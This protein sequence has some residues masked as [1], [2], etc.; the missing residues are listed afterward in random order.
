MPKPHEA[1]PGPEDAGGVSVTLLGVSKAYVTPAG[2][3]V[4]AMQDV[5]LEIAAGQ[6]VAVT[7]PSGSGKSTLLHVVGAMDSV[8]QGRVVVDGN[9]LTTMGPR[10]LVAYRRSIG[11]IFQ[12]FHLISSLTAL[13]NVLAPVIPYR[14]TFD[15]DT[16][17]TELL[18][19]VGLA[20]RIDAL[21]SRLSGG[22][23]QRVAIARALINEPQLLLADEPTG[24]LDSV[25]GGDVLELLLD[26]NRTRGVTMLI[27]THDPEVAFQCES[28]LLMRDGRISSQDAVGT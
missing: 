8:D 2:V 1:S 27:A 26:L 23:Q 18:A 3:P 25:T 24:N 17:A 12:R 11:F 20:D 5:S 14:T 22:Q 19:S 21:P 6:V 15:K 9:D 10:R 16:R 13:D 7:G 28:Q 4:Q